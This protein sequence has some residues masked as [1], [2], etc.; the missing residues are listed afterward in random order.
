MEVSELG[1]VYS[2]WFCTFRSVLLVIFWMYR[3]LE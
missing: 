2:Y 1:A 3:V